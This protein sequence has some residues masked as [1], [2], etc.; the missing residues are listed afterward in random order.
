MFY[1]KLVG[2]GVCKY[3]KIFN[4]WFFLEG[5]ACSFQCS[6]VTREF[7]LSLHIAADSVD[8]AWDIP[9]ELWWSSYR[10]VD[11]LQN[12]NKAWSSESRTKRKQGK[13][14]GVK[15]KLKASQRFT[16]LPNIIWRRVCSLHHKMG[17]LQGNVAFL[18]EYRNA[19]TWLDD[20]VT[21]DSLWLNGFLGPVRL[22]RRYWKKTWRWSVCVR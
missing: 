18:H 6:V 1:F 15:R 20:S 9:V 16:L 11:I 5:A 13:R 7:I 12:P 2:S 4:S 21:H 19:H 8:P 14:G 17:E 10:I 22:D 3:L